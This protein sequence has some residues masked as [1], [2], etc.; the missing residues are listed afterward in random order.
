MTISEIY[1]CDD[2]LGGLG[3]NKTECPTPT[4]SIAGPSEISSCPDAKLNLAAARSGGGGIKPLRFLWA[5]DRLS[6]NAQPIREALAPSYVA[7]DSVSLQAELVGG[8]YFKFL[9][10]VLLFYWFQF[11]LCH[12]CYDF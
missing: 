4:A 6:D 5:P 1:P 7:A 8:Y 3:A 9:L 11:S 10:K 2:G 12:L